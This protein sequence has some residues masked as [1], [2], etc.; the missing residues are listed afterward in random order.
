MSLG[1]WAGADEWLRPPEGE[2]GATTQSQALIAEVD[3]AFVERSR[4]HGLAAASSLDSITLRPVGPV[5]H[6]TDPQR[7]PRLVNLPKNAAASGKPG[8]H[9]ADDVQFQLGWGVRQNEVIMLKHVALLGL[10]TGLTIGSASGPAEA[11]WRGGWHVG[12]WYG[13]S[14]GWYG[15]YGWQPLYHGR[16]YPAYY[17]PYYGNPYY[18]GYY[19]YGPWWGW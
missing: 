6:R 8:Q 15:G 5:P 4:A 18:G 7:D 12:G 16:L 10:L 11:G 2:F 17:G 19:S 1:A 13:G 9:I 14:G 3:A